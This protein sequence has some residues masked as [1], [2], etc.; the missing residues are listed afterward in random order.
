M[1]NWS[2]D[3]LPVLR[4]DRDTID[5]DKLPNLIIEVFKNIFRMVIFKKETPTQ[6]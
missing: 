3:K 2:N 1:T 6:L 4:W 5:R